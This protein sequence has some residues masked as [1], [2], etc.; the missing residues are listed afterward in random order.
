MADFTTA[1]VVSKFRVAATISSGLACAWCRRSAG[2]PDL[3]ATFSFRPMEERSM[4]ELI[5]A[6]GGNF[7]TGSMLAL[8]AVTLICLITLAL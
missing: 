4:P 6:E 1:R 3:A 5:R 2:N 8:L 7:I